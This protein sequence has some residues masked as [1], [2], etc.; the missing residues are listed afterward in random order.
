MRNY[1][2]RSERLGF[3]HWSSNDFELASR[4]WMDA[5][6]MQHIGGPYT[7]EKVRARLAREIAN[8]ETLGIQYWPLFLLETNAFAGCCGLR[9]Q[10]DIMALGFHLLPE[11]WGRGLA[12][13]AAK[14]VIAHAFGSLHATTLY[15]GHNPHN[16]RSRRV[17]EALGF[18]YWRD[19]FY[20]PTGL[21]HP[22]Y[23]LVSASDSS[24][25]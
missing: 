16:T 12:P 25:R 17:L 6:V 8:Q 10:H 14:A 24:A 9:P 2:L 22:C 18:E 4:L 21:M 23:L 3:G 1:W 5:D 19:E 13:E 11:L 20:E 7:E 15:A